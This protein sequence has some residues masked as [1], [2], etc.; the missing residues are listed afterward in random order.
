M[1]D[2]FFLFLISCTLET[3]VRVSAEGDG[4]KVARIHVVGNFRSRFSSRV[5]R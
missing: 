3:V 5:N 4:V 2:F 1:F